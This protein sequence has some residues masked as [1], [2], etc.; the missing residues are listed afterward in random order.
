VAE[1]AAL[2]VYPVKSCRGFSRDA[3]ELDR[4]GLRLD[5]AFMVVEG[6]GRFLTQREEPR[7]ALV[8]TEVRG[9]ELVL[10]ADGDE[11]ALPTAGAPGARVQAV[12]W[13]HTGPAVDQGDAVARWLSARLG[14]WVRLVRIPDDHARRVNPARFVGEAHTSFSDGYPLLVIGEASLADLNVRLP[15]PLPMARFRPNLVVRGVPPYAE[16]RWRRVRIG[17]VEVAIVK[18][19]ERCQVTT[20]D[21]DTAERRGPEPLRTLATYRRRGNQ[22]CFGQNAVHL[23]PGRL[24]VG[25]R[26]EVLEEAGPE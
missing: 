18:P 4:L 12:V 6:D 13:G 25:A 5:R 14:R 9:D 17:A 26:L 1:L 16:D 15:A 3:W 2:S 20:I 21:P 22:V 11:I 7:L 10:A 23:G 8:A 24:E 19:C